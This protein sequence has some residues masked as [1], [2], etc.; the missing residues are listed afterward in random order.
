MFFRLFNV[1]LYI[2]I[3]KNNIKTIQTD[4]HGKSFSNLKKR[5][6]SQI[7]ETNLSKWKQK[8]DWLTQ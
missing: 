8:T 3:N 5:N 6:S 4:T 2:I 1:T 7:K